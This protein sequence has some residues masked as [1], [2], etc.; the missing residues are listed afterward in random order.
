MKLAQ[1]ITRIKPSAT[2]TINTKAQELRAAGRRIVSLAVGEPDS[3]TPEH[4]CD[5]AK[6][7][8]GDVAAMEAAFRADARLRA[9][10]EIG[11]DYYWDAATADVQKRLFRDQLALAR[12]LSLPGVEDVLSA[13]GYSRITPKKVIGRLLPKKEGEEGDVHLKVEAP[14][15][16]A[17]SVAGTGKGK[18]GEG[19]RIQGVDNVLVRLA[20]CCNPVPGDPIVGYIS[21]GR[22][23]VV[24]THD[25]PNIPN[26]ESERLIQVN[27]EGEK[28]HPYPAGL[29][30]LAKNQKGVLGKI[31]QMLAE[32]GVN[33][34]SGAIHS[35]IDG[36][37][38]LVFRIEVRDSS[39]LYRTIDRL[40]RLDAVIAVKRRAVTDELGAGPDADENAE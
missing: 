38:Q 21:R 2:L 29:S 22:G 25:C 30:I 35:N 40:S 17:D 4:V 31:S 24:H 19:V 36:T 5:A 1:R 15:A 32:E 28:E 14:A 10:G 11:L 3:R 34:D 12:E 33:I 20:Q 9:V 18:P 26:L 23:V 6:A 7:A 27:W 39:H 16:P 13:V 37:S 8:P